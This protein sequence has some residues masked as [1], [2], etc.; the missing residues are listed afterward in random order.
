[1]IVKIKENVIDKSKKYKKNI[2]GIKKYVVAFFK[3]KGKMRKIK[4]L[5][6]MLWLFIIRKD[7]L[8]SLLMTLPF[9]F[10]DIFTRIHGNSVSFYSFFR[11]TPRLF[12]ITYI[13]LFIGISLNIKKK[14]SKLVYS[15]F[16]FIFFGLFIVQNIYYSTMNNFFGFSLMALIN[17]DNIYIKFT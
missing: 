17:T 13:I 5:L 7:V 10:M 3:E 9:V 16:F 8:I 14:Y 1:M 4:K 6:K 15:I 11:I 12:S 2:S